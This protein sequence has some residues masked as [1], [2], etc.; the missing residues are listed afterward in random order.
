MFTVTAVFSEPA[1]AWFSYGIWSA[2]TATRGSI[3]YSGVSG[4]MVRASL[5]ALSFGNST[6]TYCQ[7]SGGTATVYYGANSYAAVIPKNLNLAGINI[8]VTPSASSGVF[9]DYNNDSLFVQHDPGYNENIGGAKCGTIGNKYNFG[10]LSLPNI[11]LSLQI[12]QEL[13]IGNYRGMFNLKYSLSDPHATSSAEL[14]RPSNA[15]FY[16]NS[17][18]TISVPYNITITG[19]C[20]ITPSPV[21][22]EHGA[23]TSQLAQN[24]EKQVSVSV[25]CTSSANL[26]LQISTN[27]PSTNQYT[28]SLGVALG[29][30]WDSALKMINNA[31]GQQGKQVAVNAIANVNSPVVISSTLKNTANSQIGTL[32]GS[33]TITV[34][35]Q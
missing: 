4:G 10:S 29:N 16:Q 23:L 19:S 27:T 22:L 25:L 12:P 5:G 8:P 24:N 15:E 3:N 20:D 13:P 6:L 14:R 18:S 21:T 17:V 32:N 35:I 26:S 9:F 11:T 2:D 31:N 7:S 30:G 28:N 34:T 1:M 33:A